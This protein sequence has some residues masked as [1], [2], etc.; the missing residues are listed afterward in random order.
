MFRTWLGGNNGTLQSFSKTKFFSSFLDFPF[1]LKDGYV[2]H[3][4][5]LYD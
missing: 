3:N 5:K 4:A 2:I 1:D